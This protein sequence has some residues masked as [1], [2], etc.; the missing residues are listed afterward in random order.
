MY[1]LPYHPMRWDNK[2][3]RD[4][5]EGKTKGRWLG[6]EE[7]IDKLP[8]PLFS[9]LYLSCYFLLEMPLFAICIWG[10][11][12]LHPVMVFTDIIHTMGC[13]IGIHPH[14]SLIL[15]S[16]GR[17]NNYYF[18]PNCFSY[19]I[20]YPNNLMITDRKSMLFKLA[21]QKDRENR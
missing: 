13:F 1:S 9:I 7:R 17:Y 21:I 14:K 10:E 12:L 15:N 8:Q 4:L 11:A 2:R 19:V 6:I 16:L 20:L 3:M 18:C 5:I